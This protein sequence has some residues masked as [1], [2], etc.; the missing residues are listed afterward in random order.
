MAVVAEVPF[1]FGINTLGTFLPP[2][3]LVQDGGRTVRL[4]Y[5][6]LYIVRI[7]SELWVYV[8][9]L[10]SYLRRVQLSTESIIK[11]V[12]IHSLKNKE[13]A[14]FL[15]VVTIAK[16]VVRKTSMKEIVTGIFTSNFGLVKALLFHMGREIKLKKRYLSHREFRKRWRAVTILLRVNK[17]V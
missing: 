17:H 16:G 5:M 3:L 12:P 10:S 2:R 14:C 8:E 4:L 9:L 7:F 11:I 15:T 1:L 13:K 6:Q